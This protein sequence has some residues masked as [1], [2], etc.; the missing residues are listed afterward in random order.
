[1]YPNPSG[2]SKHM[3]NISISYSGNVQITLGKGTV[4]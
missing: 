4:V 1:M 3:N 2:I